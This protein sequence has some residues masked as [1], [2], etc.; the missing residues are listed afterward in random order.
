LLSRSEVGMDVVLEAL[1]LWRE[2]RPRK[3]D[4]LLSYARMRRVER[5]LR[6]YLQGLP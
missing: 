2:Q 5:N 4:T 3:L 1:R 6:P